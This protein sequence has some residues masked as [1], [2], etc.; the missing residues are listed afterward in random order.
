MMKKVLIIGATGSVGST[1]RDY[2]LANSDDQLTLFAR[3]ANRLNQTN[4]RETAIQGDVT[5]VSDLATAMQGQDVVFAALSGDLKAMAESIISAMHQTQVTR[6][7]FITSMGIYNEIPASLG[8]GGNVE[9][10]PMLRGYRAAADVI[11]ASDLD[12]TI[13]R[14]GWFDNGSDDYEVTQKGE[15][16]GGHD[17]SRRAIA[18]LVMHAADDNDYVKASVGINRPE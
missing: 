4:P 3:H 15:P 18:D 13:V 10:N 7:I 12:Y 17:V 2:L 8:A 6:L 1:V 16:F 5:N 9:S 14:P 11:E